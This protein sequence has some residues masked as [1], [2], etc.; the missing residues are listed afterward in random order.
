M[1]QKP[2]D[3]QVMKAI[4]ADT[5]SPENKL[6]E[7]LQYL[8]KKPQGYCAVHVHLS[9]LQKTNLKPDYIRIAERAFDEIRLSHNSD[10]FILGNY[11]IFLTCPGTKVSGIDKALAAVKSLFKADPLVEKRDISGEE[12]FSSWYDLEEDFDYFKEAVVSAILSGKKSSMQAGYASMDDEKLT[13]KNLDQLAR[14][15][16]KLDARP[17]MRNQSAVKIGATGQGQLLFREYFVSIGDLRKK[18]APNIDLLADRWLFQFLTTILDQRVLHMLR[19]QSM[20][21]LPKNVSLNLNLQTIHSKDFQLFDQFV[22]KEANRIILEFQP[23]DVF[24]NINDYYEVRDLLQGRGYKV[25]IDALQPLVLDYFDPSMLSAD[26]YKIAWGDRLGGST[27]K[28]GAAET[29]EL[30]HSIG[31]SKVVIS[32]V[33]SEEAIKYG[34]QLGVS[35]FQGFFVDK[36]VSAMTQQVA[37]GA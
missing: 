9:Q 1:A 37:K 28:E 8:E 29:R 27:T 14:S 33:D 24:S 5:N 12:S 22:G 2:N 31:S 3:A 19:T 26:F 7:N 23:V 20:D 30:I 6:L 15:F 13:P 10:L 18:I 34:L 25:L 11:D 21:D 16:K 32:H 36:L 4:R 17:L 35:R